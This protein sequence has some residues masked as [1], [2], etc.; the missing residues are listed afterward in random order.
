MRRI[1]G[2]LSLLSLS[3]LPFAPAEGAPIWLSYEASWAGLPAGNIELRLEEDAT[4]YRSEI[5]IRTVGLPRWFTRFRGLGISE[6]AVTKAGLAAPRAYDAYYDLRSR[7]NKC[8]SLRFLDHAGTVV[9][10]R[11]PED[12]SA[13]SN[14]P[15]PLPSRTDV[16]DPLSTISLMRAAIRSGRARPGELRIPVYDG[17]RRFDVETRG[18]THEVERIGGV[19]RKVL[20]LA[21][22]L[23]P[24][25]GFNRHDEEGDPDAAPRPLDVLFSDDEALLP[26][27]L[28]VSIAWFTVVV[29]Q[30]GSCPAGPPPCR[31]GAR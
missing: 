30:S 19:D 16:V 26:L 10:E 13:E 23:R 20:H 4:A 22:Q 25:D 11:G 9:A 12:G 15:L 21:L 14:P 31:L 8:V 29:E 18:L 2:A 5:E 1:C 28:E 6:G 24:I 27:R 17:K 7:K 3:L